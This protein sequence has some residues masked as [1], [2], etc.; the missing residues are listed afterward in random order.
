MARLIFNNDAV[1]GETFLPGQL[2]MFGGFTLRANSIGYPKQIDSYTPSNQIRFG[3]LNYVADTRGV[4]IFKGFSA[5]TAPHLQEGNP[6]G[7]LSDLV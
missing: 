4:L 7:P 6:S 1:S 2:F 5:P 3:S